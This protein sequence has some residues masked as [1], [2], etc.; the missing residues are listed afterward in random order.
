MVDVGDEVSLFL[1]SKDAV[2]M[3]VDDI[4]SKKALQLLNLP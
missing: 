2:G 1:S 3:E 4:I